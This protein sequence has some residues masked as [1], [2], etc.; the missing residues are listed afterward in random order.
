MKSYIRKPIQSRILERKAPRQKGMFSTLQLVPYVITTKDEINKLSYEQ[1]CFFVSQI[2]RKELY[3]T[4]MP[5]NG[6]ISID[7]ANNELVEYF[8]KTHR[9]NKIGENEILYENMI[10]TTN[11][12]IIYPGLDSCI[13]ISIIKLR[14][15]GSKLQRGAH[16]VIP[17][18]QE[19]LQHYDMLLSS[20]VEFYEDGDII[21]IASK[22]KDDIDSHINW[23]KQNTFLDSELVYKVTEILKIFKRK[24]IFKTESD[25]KAEISERF[26]SQTIHST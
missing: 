19:P 7:Y 24:A 25:D 6:K 13:G 15:D 23:I 22:N 10:G 12:D 11:R 8:K 2:I 1:I 17:F 20:L 21:C 3:N 9:V 18:E 5:W 26:N 16:M 14:H 4:A